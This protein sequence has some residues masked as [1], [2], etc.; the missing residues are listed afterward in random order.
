VPADVSVVG[1]DDIPV[2]R[3][4]EPALGTMR[5]P[6]REVGRTALTVLL[7]GQQGPVQRREQILLPAE[8]M[9][10]DSTAPATASTTASDRL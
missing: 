4:V 7:D 1:Y 2:A 5:Q 6:M 8:L 9:V 3:F 10:R